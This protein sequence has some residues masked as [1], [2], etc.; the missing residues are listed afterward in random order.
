VF[1]TI[2]YCSIF[3]DRVY[4]IDE[5][6]PF[7]T[8]FLNKYLT[9]ESRSPDLYRAALDAIRGIAN[10]VGVCQKEQPD[11]V[12]PFKDFLV[13]YIC[14]YYLDVGESFVADENGP[15]EM[16]KPILTAL[17]SLLPLRPLRISDHYDRAIEL[18]AVALHLAAGQQFEV[19]AKSSANFFTT[20][21]RTQKYP[22]EPP[23]LPPY[24]STCDL[25][26]PKNDLFHRLCF[27]ASRAPS[28]PFTR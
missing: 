9:H 17:S 16:V 27:T 18:T 11:H 4:F 12:F 14:S 3:I 22:F 20:L 6:L 13:Q 15:I 25:N 1:R 24:R 23:Y 2:H 5:F 8:Q 26:P 28:V 10:A 21:L 19:V 7:A